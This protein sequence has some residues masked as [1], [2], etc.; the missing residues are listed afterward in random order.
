V[1]DVVL[2]RHG[3]TSWTGRRYCGR[4]DPPLDPV[5]RVGVRALAASLAPTLPRDLLIVTSPARRARETA[6]FLA[7]AAGVADI[8]VD[9]RWHEADFGIAEGRTFEE[10]DALDP[11]L[12]AALARGVIDIDWPGGETA[13]EVAARIAAA[14]ADLL[15]RARASVVVSHAG[16]LRHAVA[17][18]DGLSL[19]AAR[20][21]GPAQ[22]LRVGGAA[23]LPGTATVLRSLP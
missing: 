16:A 10:L 12:A 23:E 7:D 21:L 15:A 17:L 19:H 11:D 5:G 3:T 14:W 9:E 6:A 18:A 8:V 20:S 13:A 2:V 1:I 4:S 22:A